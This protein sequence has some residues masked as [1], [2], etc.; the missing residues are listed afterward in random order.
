MLADITHKEIY[1]EEHY[2]AESVFN[3]WK[4]K[5]LRRDSNFEACLLAYF[6]AVNSVKV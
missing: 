1:A 2:L 4:H 3:V 5:E 6:F